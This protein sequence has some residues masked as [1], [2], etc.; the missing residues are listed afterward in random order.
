M[1]PVRLWPEAPF[2]GIAHLAERHLAKVE[3]ASS[4][5]VARSTSKHTLTAPFPPCGEN[6]AGRVCFS[7][8]ERNYSSVRDLE[9]KLQPLVL[10]AIL[11]LKSIFHFPYKTES[12]FIF[13]RSVLRKVEIMPHPRRGKIVT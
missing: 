11:L 10:A 8:S 2:A 4:N 13:E 6:C 1:S 7:S 9:G 12:R 5:L 3:V